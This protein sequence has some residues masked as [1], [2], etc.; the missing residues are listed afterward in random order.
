VTKER[1]NTCTIY[2]INIIITK[3]A[4][5]SALLYLVQALQQIISQSSSKVYK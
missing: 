1:L 2:A 4:D 3:N 5:M